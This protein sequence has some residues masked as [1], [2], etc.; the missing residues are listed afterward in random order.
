MG[1]RKPPD[2]N[3]SDGLPLSL[4]RIACELG[5]SVTTVSRALGGFDDVAASTRA[6]VL[7]EA[8]RIHYRPNQAAR[9]LR[10][11]RSGAV[12]IVIPTA[13]GQFGDPFFLRM[14]A[15]IGPRLDRAGLDLLVTTARPGQDELRAYRKLVEGRR[16]DGMILLRTRVHDDRIAYL[17]DAGLPFVTHGRSVEARPFASVDVDGEAAGRAATERLIEFGH[18]AIGLI[19]AADIYMFARHRHAGWQA[20]LADAGLPRGPALAAEPTEENGFLL[21][22]AMLAPSHGN[23]ARSVPS[24]GNVAQSAPSHANVAPTA[25][26]HADVAPTAP[27]HGNVAPTAIVCA[28]DRLAVGA[29]HACHESGL[30]V[31]RDISIIGYDDLPMARH[32][33]PPLTTIEQPADRSALRMVDML[34]QLLDGASPVG[35]QEIWQARLIP[36]SSDG[37]VTPTITR[38]T[39][40]VTP[41]SNHHSGEKNVQRDALT[42]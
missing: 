3:V 30:R 9:R 23:V 41:P 12:G 35:M 39:A 10:S 20:A 5:L 6:R 14:L 42:P 22:R 36:R 25:P 13:P 16:V 27:S 19:N 33:E 26:S 21:A 1:L 18:R 29:I 34:L 8:A 32:I 40:R 28:T 17:L 4:V 24:H 15:S 7:A 11:G 38:E 31:G 37:P 2:Q